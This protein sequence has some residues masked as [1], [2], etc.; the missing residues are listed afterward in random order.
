MVV[1]KGTVSLCAYNGIASVQKA[2]DLK[3]LLPSF[4]LL[5]RNNYTRLLRLKSTNMNSLYDNNLW[6][7]HPKET[8]SIFQTA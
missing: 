3:V 2:A 1:S 7:S 6:M 4:Q 5:H 8:V